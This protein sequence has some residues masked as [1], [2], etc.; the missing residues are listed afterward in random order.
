MEIGLYTEC[1]VIQRLPSHVFD[2]RKLGLSTDR[3]IALNPQSLGSNA[4]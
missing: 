2:T 3:R 1:G 4:Q